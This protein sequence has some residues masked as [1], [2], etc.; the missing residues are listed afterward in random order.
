MLNCRS[1]LGRV[2]G[3]AVVQVSIFV[4]LICVC[5][6]QRASAQAQNTGVVLGRITDN[7][8]LAVASATVSLQ[9]GDQGRIVTVKSN[10][11]GE[12]I[13]N[14]VP[15]GT[16]TITVNAKTFAIYTVSQLSVNAGEN[17]TEDVVLRAGSADASVNVSADSLSVDTQSA[18]VGF[19]ID[20]NLVQNLPLDGNNVV[21]MAALLPGVTDVNAPTTFTSDTG[22]PTYTAGGSRAN[23]NLLLLDGAL[24]NNLYNNT[25]LNFPPHQALHEVSV[26]LNNYKAQY[27]RNVG[28]VFNVLTDSGTNAFHGQI[29]EFL[30]NTAFNA[31]DYLSHLNPHLVSNQ[32]G[33][34]LGGPVRRDK[35][36]FTLTFQDLRQAAVVTAQTQTPTMSERGLNPDGS[37]RTCLNPAFA[38]Y[39]C[40]YFYDA[41][42]RNYNGTNTTTT[43]LDNPLSTA[44]GHYSEYQPQA[45]SALQAAWQVAGNTGTS[46]CITLLQSQPAYL[47]TPELP[48]IC[49]N[50]VAVKLLQY[51]P[52]P[53][54]GSEAVTVAPQPRNDMGGLAR[55]DWNLAHHA[56]SARY[57]QTS[58]N[59]ATA[60]GVSNGNGIASYEVNLNVGGIHFGSIDDTW[61]LTPSLVNT[62]RAAYKRYVYDI[63]PGN[64]TSLTDLGASLFQPGHDALP[65]LNIVGQVQAGSTTQNYRNSVNEDVELDDSLAWTKG[66]HNYQ[67]GLEY[68]RLQYLASYDQQP[69]ISFNI[70]H[71]PTPLADFLLGMAQSTTVGNGNTQAAIQHDLYLYAQDDWRILPRLTIS[72]GI[73]YE[74]PLQWYQPDGQAA[75]FIPGYKSVINPQSPINLA[76]VGDP[77]IERSLVGTSFN[78]VAPRIGLAYDLFGNGKTSIRAGFGIFYDAINAQIVGVTEPYHF[79]EAIVD[80]PGGLSELLLGQTQIPP[81]YVKG[82]TPQF[83]APF[84][85]TYPDPN[86]RT[87][88]TEAFNFGFQQHL[89]KSSVLEVNYVGKTGR[90]L[91]LGV[92]MN[93]AIYD[94]TGA[95]FQLNPATYCTGATASQTSYNARVQYPNFN[96]GGVGALDYMSIGSSSYNAVQTIYTVRARKRL[97]MVASYVF[98][99]SLDN[100]SNGTSITNTSPSPSISAYRALSDFNA[101]HVFNLGFQYTLPTIAGSSRFVRAIANGWF[102]GGIYTA[103]TGHPFS[104][105]DGSDS[106]LRDERPEYASFTPGGYQSLPSSRHR[107]DKVMQWFNTVTICD[108][109]QGY[110]QDAISTCPYTGANYGKVPRNFFVGPAFINTSF[111]LRRSFQLT[112][113]GGKN[114]DFRVDAFNAFNTPNLGQP[115]A[116][117]TAT[118]ATVSQPLPPCSGSTFGK[119]LATVGTNGAVGTNGR[120]LQLSGT[121]R[122]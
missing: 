6:P 89:S 68:L 36:F 38:A 16:Y 76:F 113:A 121:L 111:S 44:A 30:Q 97:S 77:G 87:P 17:I 8:G 112:P 19:T 106:T 90:H 73:R 52:I 115:G 18:T 11:Q 118:G 117:C 99:K 5:I 45:L 12:Y 102:F 93:P 119:I 58:A 47:P 69:S 22:G 40:A 105:L 13:F 70:T 39:T 94:C 24:W 83:V 82:Q 7:A 57:Y 79:Q 43:A 27:G 31:S 75:T 37:A 104:I 95:Y 109:P 2:T 108:P 122:F 23:Q 28:S 10:S 72:Y 46:P 116:T 42:L 65:Y 98:S 81:N 101:R 85:I 50:P 88:Y 103:R 59:D 56:I 96:F 64:P 3:L 4:L 71:T 100:S 48:S 51:I 63:R 26:L 62:A 120:R 61:I 78:N 110:A 60:N 55:I 9:S 86:F 84:S 66:K 33:A 25:G 32:F 92:D 67:F 1:F 49:F 35:I 80:P 54:S 14:A 21:E 15:I 74:I 29:W 107:A 20:Q 114:L 41:G 34:T 53:T 91:A